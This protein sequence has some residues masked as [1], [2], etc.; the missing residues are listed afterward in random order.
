MLKRLDGLADLK[1]WLMGEND[2]G[3]ITRQEAVSMI[4]P[5]LLA[6]DPSHR[7]L[8]MCASP[9]SKT[10]Q[11]LEFLMSERAPS[12]YVLAND[13]DM[14]RCH[15]LIHQC[16]RLQS[17]GFAV[18]C[19]EAQF[20]PRLYDRHDLADGRP[21]PDMPGMFDRILADVPCSG[22]GTLRKN[23]DIF[24][25]WSPHDG[26][27][28]HPLQIQIAQKGLG[29]LQP[30][31]YLVYST[32]SMNPIE[33]EAVIAELLRAGGPEFELVDVSGRLEG[34]RRCAGVDDWKVFDRSLRPVPSFADV[35][36]RVEAD[37]DARA[38]RA[39]HASMFPPSNEE[40]ALFHLDRCVRVLPHQQDSGGFFI[41]L[42]HRK[43]PEGGY[44]AP[45]PA[46]EAAAAGAAAEEEKEA[47]GSGAVESEGGATGG[48]GGAVDEAVDEA[49]DEPEKK[50]ASKGPEFLPLDPAV[51]QQLRE[52]YG[53]TDAFFDSFE[54]LVRPGSKDNRGRYV[55]CV[56]KSLAKE[57]LRSRPAGMRK[58]RIVHAGVKMFEQQKNGSY[59]IVHAG[60]C[61]L[62][63]FITKR[64]EAVPLKD[65]VRLLSASGDHFAPREFSPDMGKLV[66]ATMGALV[67]RVRPPTP[68]DL[69]EGAPPLS[70]ELRESISRVLITLW[71]GKTKIT[72]MVSKAECAVVQRFLERAGLFPSEWHK[73]ELRAAGGAGAA[74]AAAEEA[75][76][77]ATD[78]AADD[79]GADG[80][81]APLA[82]ASGADGAGAAAAVAG[83]K[84]P[85]S[86]ST[87]G[88]ASG[89]A[90]AR[91]GME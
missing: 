53:I 24:K 43:L 91:D 66:E 31:G 19:H 82:E 48:A 85:R 54:L 57:V 83:V 90:G 77:A 45:A 86:D 63:P 39:F 46:A 87:D 73:Q 8:D 71:R 67:V 7:V 22:D 79:E 25:R 76:D 42:L 64:I 33:D 47:G 68:D 13:V 81:S 32:C 62:Q 21:A 44:A 27:S 20:M 5:L 74:E 34:L 78:T 36:A 6:V 30:G 9:G 80:S 2:T 51:V 52:D 14:K 15:T 37:D 72:C 88:E 75:K 58:L 69:P 17:P 84:R 59:R 49:A 41:A 50:R 29:Q 35:V 11:M 70:D 4:P 65:V 1:E 38:V 16:K 10:G 23:A 28:L 56:T 12:G 26:I 3:A 18:I 40:R 60:V 89:G 55:Q 61:A